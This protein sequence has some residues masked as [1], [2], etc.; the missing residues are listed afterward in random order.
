VGKIIKVL[1]QRLMNELGRTF[2]KLTDK[3]K[4]GVGELE[5]IMLCIDR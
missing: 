1:R 2:K 3:M 5:Q 4:H